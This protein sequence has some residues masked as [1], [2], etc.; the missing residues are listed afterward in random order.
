MG[1]FSFLG[2]MGND[3]L[4][5]SDSIE[6]QQK[7][8]WKMWNA[9][10][11]YNHP[12]EQVKRLEEAGLNPMLVYGNGSVAGNTSSAVGAGSGS[13]N[14]AMSS[15]LSFLNSRA[16][17]SLQEQALAY[18]EQRLYQNLELGQ[19]QIEQV[20]AA[21]NSVLAD[22]AIKQHN[23]EVARDTGAYVGDSSK[24]GLGVGFWRRFVDEAKRFYNGLPK[25]VKF[26]KDYPFDFLGM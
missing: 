5:V 13:G 21:K 18:E 15:I 7:F 19:A 9:N 20:Q 10:N 2:R 25:S 3:A 24:Y 23:L 22:I 8:S 4:G 6:Q 16:G 1:A 26:D 11:A 17:R 14:S 12:K